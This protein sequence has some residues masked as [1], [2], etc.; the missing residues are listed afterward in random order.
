[1]KREEKKDEIKGWLL[2][3]ALAAILTWYVIHPVPRSS[4]RVKL[5]DDLPEADRHQKRTQSGETSRR[6]GIRAVSMPPAIPSSTDEDLP[7][8]PDYIDVD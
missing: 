8:W 3:L 2:A 5:E 6:F 7:D 1:M 4:S